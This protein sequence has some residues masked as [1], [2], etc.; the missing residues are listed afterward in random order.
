[1]SGSIHTSAAGAI[2]RSAHLF[3]SQCTALHSESNAHTSAPSAPQSARKG[4][5]LTSGTFTLPEG[6][7]RSH[8]EAGISLQERP[9]EWR[10]TGTG[11]ATHR[12]SARDAQIA[13]SPSREGGR[14]ISHEMPFHF[15]IS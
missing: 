1:S 5:I 7:A 14:A 15:R 6:T 3:P 13:L 9:S 8:S 2:A 11:P 10:I 12:S 4:R